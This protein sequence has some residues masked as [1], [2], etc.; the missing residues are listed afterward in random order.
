MCRGHKSC[1]EFG[2]VSTWSRNSPLPPPSWI[3]EDVYK[4]ASAVRIAVAGR[5]KDAHEIVALLRANEAMDWYIEHAQIAANHR[6][7]VLN[8]PRGEEVA[9]N[10]VNTPARLK[11]AVWE[12]DRFICRYCG[13]PTIPPE[14]IKFVR[15]VIGEGLLPWGSTNLGKHG[16]LFLAR[17]EYDHVVPVSLGGTDSSDNLVTSC[18]TCNYG[19]DRW[20]VDELG[21]D[22]PRLRP[23]TESDWDGL[24]S[25]HRLAKARTV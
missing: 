4:L 2:D 9:G 8:I 15:A 12:R 6:R 7:R 19:K 25:L 22:D 24:A 1:S 14:T 16:T 18:P 23:I 3:V 11:R 20:S 10:R 21:M 17:S 13:I 5:P